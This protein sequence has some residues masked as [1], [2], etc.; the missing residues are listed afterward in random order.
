MNKKILITGLELITMTLIKFILIISLSVIGNANAAWDVWRLD[1]ILNVSGKVDLSPEVP[2]GYF[3]LSASTQSGPGTVVSADCSNIKTK[4]AKVYF[5][6]L[7]KKVNI[8]TEG[9]YLTFEI[10]GSGFSYFTDRNEWNI[11]RKWEEANYEYNSCFSVGATY[12]KILYS[13]GNPKVTVT[14]HNSDELPPGKYTVSASFLSSYREDRGDTVK[15]GEEAAINYLITGAKYNLLTINV[16]YNIQCKANIS[17]ITLNFD[18]FSATE[19]NGKISNKVPLSINCNAVASIN[20]NLKGNSPISGTAPNYTN[21]ENNNACIL[22][23]SD[24]KSYHQKSEAKYLHESVMAIFKPGSS[25]ELT[26][27]TF[28]GDGILTITYH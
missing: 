8:G 12:D 26:P 4:G 25:E 20:L 5:L 9:T 2:K 7:P 24:G 10:Q 3:T 13:W 17:D 19:A 6:A 15:A 1:D 16:D 27:G 14:L 23:F 11:Y 22:V 21:C 28:Q 18:S